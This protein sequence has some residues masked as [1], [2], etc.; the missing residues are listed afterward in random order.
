MSQQEIDAAE[1]LP[2]EERVSHSHWKVRNSAYEAIL[3]MIQ[4]GAPE[5]AS[6]GGLF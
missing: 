4:Q 6:I 3:A 5:L 2:L 1:K